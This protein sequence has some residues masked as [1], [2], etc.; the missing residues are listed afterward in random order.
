MFE[1]LRVSARLEH[2]R[3]VGGGCAALR[4]VG[5]GCAGEEL[6]TLIDLVGGIANARKYAAQYQIKYSSNG[7]WTQ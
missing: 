6:A 7:Q 2:M 5:G 4:P 1:V 3:I